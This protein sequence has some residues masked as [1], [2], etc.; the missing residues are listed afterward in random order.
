MTDVKVIA[1]CNDL[2]RLWDYRFLQ[3]VHG[4]Y[5]MN[6]TADKWKGSGLKAKWDEK[7]HDEILINNCPYCGKSL[8][9]LYET[10]WKGAGY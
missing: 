8:Y 3:Y 9:G 4:V 6:I 2:Q 10:S 1:C 7:I 5:V